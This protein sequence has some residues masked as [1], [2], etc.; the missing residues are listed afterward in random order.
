MPIKAF[1]E[2]VHHTAYQIGS[3]FYQ[4]SKT[5]T[6][7]EAKQICICDRNTGAIY[8]GASAR[9]FL[10]LPHHGAIRLA[11][12]NM[13]NYDVFVQSTSVNRKLVGET[14]VLYCPMFAR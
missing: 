1:M 9:D 4:L 3:V 11:P 6:L 7:Q 12:H 5:E 8:G 10:G 13:A 2:D 14:V